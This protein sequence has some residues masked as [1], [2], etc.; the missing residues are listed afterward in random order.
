MFS[1]FGLGSSNNDELSQEARRRVA[2]GAVLLDVRTAEEFATGHLPGAKNIPV[3]ELSA[4]LRELPP[5]ASVV[6][7]CRSG[8]R[9][10]AATQIL[11]GRGHDVLDIATMAAWG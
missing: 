3:Q 6:V 11:W 7:Y 9:S 2:A 5:K 1:F 8:G 4:R 10:A